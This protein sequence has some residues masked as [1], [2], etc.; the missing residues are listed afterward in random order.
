MRLAI[1]W[2]PLSFN[3]PNLLPELHLD[4]TGQGISFYDYRQPGS[5]IGED[6]QGIATIISSFA[7]LV[8]QLDFHCIGSSANASCDYK[9]IDEILYDMYPSRERREVAHW[10]LCQRAIDLVSN[11]RKPVDAVAKEL[12][13]RPTIERHR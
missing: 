1:S 9:L 8:A 2:L 5:R 13:N 3:C 12:W 11:H 6:A 7:G 10:E 4:A